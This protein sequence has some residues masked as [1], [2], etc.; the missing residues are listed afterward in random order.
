VRRQTPFLNLILN[1]GLTWRGVMANTFLSKAILIVKGP[2]LATGELQSELE[3]RGANVVIADVEFAFSVLNHLHFDGAIIDGELQN[4]AFDLCTE[5]QALYVPYISVTNPHCL[6]K[7]ASQA[8]D[9]E[10]ALNRLV[11]V[12]SRHKDI[13]DLLLGGDPASMDSH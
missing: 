6:Q 5:L 9:V 2:R 3:S 10:N 8:R 12:I 13:D 1:T 7:F 4:E 11:E